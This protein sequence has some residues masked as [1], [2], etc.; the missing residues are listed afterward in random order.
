MACDISTTQREKSLSA[1]VLNAYGTPWICGAGGRS[2]SENDR[3]AA[4]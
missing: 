2:D 3:Y 1:E 4:V